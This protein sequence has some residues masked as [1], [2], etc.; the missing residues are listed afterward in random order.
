MIVGVDPGLKVGYAALDLDGNLIS[1]GCTKNKAQEKIISLISKVGIPSLIA[2]D[3]NPAPK[4]VKKIAARF[5][6][7]CHS[8]RKSISK[9]CKRIIGN[10]ISNPH[11]RDAYS[12]AIKAYRNYSNRLT[13]INY[14]YPDLKERYKHLI[15]KGIPVGKL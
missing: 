14:T 12:A 10:G 1:S 15:L 6:V 5:N 13:R 9:E 2:T 11:I 3:V 7:K 4:F 8:P